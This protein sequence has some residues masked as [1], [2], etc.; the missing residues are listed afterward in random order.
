MRIEENH[1][2]AI[3]FQIACCNGYIARKIVKA[4]VG[5][6]AVYLL[7][8]TPS[9]IVAH[10]IIFA[11]LIAFA[12]RIT[13]TNHNNDIKKK[14]RDDQ[15]KPNEIACFDPSKED[16]E[17]HKEVHEQFATREHDGE[18]RKADIALGVVL[19]SR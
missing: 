11:L 12:I 3:R 2:V 16:N 14:Q 18:P 10:V 13:E 4:F 15:R 8:A 5:R 7:C 17:R 6:Y 19:S 1:K 9:I